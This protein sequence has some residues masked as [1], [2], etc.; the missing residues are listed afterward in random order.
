NYPGMFMDPATHIT[1]L[2]D[3]VL[4]A[5]SENNID[6]KVLVYDH[7]WDRADYP[8]TVLSDP[9]LKSSP[10]VAGIAWHGYGGTPGVMTTLYNKYRDKGN[11]QTEH[12]GGAWIPNQTKADFE[13]IIQVM[14]NWGKAYV[15]WGLA[16]DQNR[17][18]HTGGCGICS[19]LVTVNSSTGGVQ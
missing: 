4:P 19:P 1:V 6:T 14:R 9:T 16:L 5:L 10:Q 3:Y 15:K 2:R 17:G 18:P 12:S 13:E 7:N 8:D 11:Y